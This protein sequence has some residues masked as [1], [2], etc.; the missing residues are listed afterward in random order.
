MR[1]DLSSLAATGGNS[2]APQILALRTKDPVALRHDAS[3]MARRIVLAIVLLI[4]LGGLAYAGFYLYKRLVQSSGQPAA[5]TPVTSPTRSGV[6]GTTLPTPTIVEELPGAH[7]TLLKKPADAA[8]VMTLS[9]DPVT[10]PSKLQTYGQTLRTTLNTIKTPTAEIEVRNSEGKPLSFPAFLSF[11]NAHVIDTAI[12][13]DNFG[14]DFSFLV[15]RDGNTYNAAYV[16][17]L[18]DGKN[19]L[20]VRG[21]V[22]KLETS[23]GL[24]GLFPVLP[25]LRDEAGFKD[26]TLGEQQVRTLTYT[27]PD[28][29]FIYGWYRDYLILGTSQKAFRE[30][31]GRVQQ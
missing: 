7:Q 31:L 11:I 20:F 26:A 17:K 5:A 8:L 24:E 3:R 10:D 27:Q 14:P 9:N 16:V 13:Q 6:P 22:A 28:G 4:V 25:G 15:V 12:Y 18:K 2:V 21:D 1:S 29:Q 30:A 23:T 19:W